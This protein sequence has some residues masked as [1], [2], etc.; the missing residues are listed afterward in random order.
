MDK[1]EAIKILVE[2]AEL[3]EQNF[4]NKNML[5]VCQDTANKIYVYEVRFSKSNFLHLTGV[6][7]PTGK[8]INSSEFFNKCINN[9]L[10]KSDFEFS[11]DGTTQLKLNVLRMLLSQDMNASMMGDYSNYSP[12]LYTE[13][14]VGGTRACM[15]FIKND[16]GVYV[17]NTV[18]NESIKHLITNQKKILLMI[19][20]DLSNGDYTV[21]KTSSKFDIDTI[22][23]PEGYEH[24]KDIL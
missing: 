3:Y 15:G 8:R 13:K 21:V 5:I 24:I 23:M 12:R 16:K 19:T 18:L 4:K 22:V 14:L 6:K 20:K 2:S 10:S 9:R 17:P 1:S 11:K 7:P